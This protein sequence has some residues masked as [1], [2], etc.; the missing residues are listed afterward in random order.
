MDGIVSESSTR[1]LAT[2]TFHFKE[3]RLQFL[4]QVI[5]NL[6]EFPVDLDLIVITNVD[7]DIRIAKIETLCHPLFE[8]FPALRKKQTLSIKSFPHLTDPWQL[9]WCHKQLIKD[10]FVAPN[11]TYTHFIYSEDDILIT[12]DNFV[13]F[14]RYRDLL[15]SRRL[16]PSFH[17][18]EYN[19]EDNCLYLSDQ[20]GV[21]NFAQ[22][23]RV[24]LDGYAFINLDY[25][26]NAMFI[27]DRDLALEYV[28]SQ[29]FDRNLSKLIQ[30]EWDIAC[31]SAMGLCF[32]NPPV[33]FAHRYVS[34]VNPN[35]LATPFWSWVYHVPNNYVTNRYTALGK[36]RVD[37]LF[38]SKETVSW[39]P[40]PKILRYLHRAKLRLDPKSRS[41]FPP[42]D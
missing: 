2:I 6:I 18:I 32:E 34:P 5:R 27:L 38:A 8:N 12:Y 23:S 22:R 39:R 37:Q 17:R 30:P 15:K 40:P 19:T 4:F 28:I 36:T 29:S 21:S 7:D 11:S 10:T 13:Y 3:S 1:V 16:I 14:L 42:R 24:E 33:G 25:P 26:Y 31:R 9:T 20:E 41:K 35:T